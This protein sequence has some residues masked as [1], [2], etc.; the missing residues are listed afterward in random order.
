M[1]QVKLRVLKGASMEFEVREGTT[2]S[3]LLDMAGIDVDRVLAVLLNGR[4]AEAGV[5]LGQGDVISIFP[6]VAGG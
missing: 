5:E 4:Y 3:G 6:P 2:C 1:P